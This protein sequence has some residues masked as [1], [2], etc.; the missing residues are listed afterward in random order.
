MIPAVRHCYFFLFIYFCL[1]WV[2]I[3]AQSFIAANGGHSPVS[4]VISRFS[5]FSCCGAR[6][7]GRAGSEVAGPEPQGTGSEVASCCMACGTLPDQGSDPSL[8][9]W[10]WIPHHWATRE[11]QTSLFLKHY[12]AFLP[13]SLT[14]EPQWKAGLSFGPDHYIPRCTG[15][16]CFQTEVCLLN[17]FD[18]SVCIPVQVISLYSFLCWLHLLLIQFLVS[19][20]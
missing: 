1:C 12:F 6:A 16:C 14:T 18:P 4:C 9:H 8:L 17:T 13:K 20:S 11:A 2:F 5:G 10:W 7:P 3:A 19:T 15:N